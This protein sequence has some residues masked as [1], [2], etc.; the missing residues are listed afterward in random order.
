MA[1]AQISRGDKAGGIA[2]LQAIAAGMTPGDPRIQAIRTVVADA[3]G[4]AAPTA[5]PAFSGDQM[6]AIR[7]MV[8]GLA[9]RLQAQ[10]DDPEGWVRLVR[11]YAVL[12]DAPKRD[13]ALKAA[14][15]RYAG[16]AEI[17]EQLKAAAAAPPMKTAGIK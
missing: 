3:Q 16:K 7:G 10:P 8:A 14:N 6:T 9:E 12:G 1:R 2:A 4:V 15:A 11:A 17:L 13:A 5:E